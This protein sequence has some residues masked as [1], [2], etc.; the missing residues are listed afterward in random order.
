MNS[1]I[2]GDLRCY[3]AH[4]T[5]MQRAFMLLQKW[6]LCTTYEFFWTPWELHQFAYDNEVI[7]DVEYTILLCRDYMSLWK[8]QQ[9]KDLLNILTAKL[10]KRGFG[11]FCPSVSPAF[12]APINVS[13]R[14]TDLFLFAFCSLYLSTASVKFTLSSS[15]MFVAKWVLDIYVWSHWFE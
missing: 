6:R 13:V 9:I 12:L 15:F 14:K 3:K 8:N 5:V 1:P 10:T 4:V 11:F 2:A 7:V